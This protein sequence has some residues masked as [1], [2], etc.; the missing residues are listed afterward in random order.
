MDDPTEPN[1]PIPLQ[2]GELDPDCPMIRSVDTLQG[3]P[4]PTAAGEVLITSQAVEWVR[5]AQLHTVELTS[6]E[7]DV[8][9]TLVRNLEELN[10]LLVQWQRDEKL[11]R[12]VDTNRIMA[13]ALAMDQKLIELERAIFKNPVV[14]RL[15][16]NPFAP[17]VLANN[18][19][20]G[21]IRRAY[22]RLGIRDPDP[23]VVAKTVAAFLAAGI[24]PECRDSGFLSRRL[25]PHLSVFLGGN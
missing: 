25:R 9:D 24:D 8:K 6:R 14:D 2:P 7:N 13:L 23:T 3:V 21:K 20:L 17:P 15:D 10:R 11:R 4:L 5:Q 12:D 16:L 19:Q 22:R 18:D 1:K